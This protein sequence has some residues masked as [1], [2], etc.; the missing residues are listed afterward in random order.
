MNLEVEG[1]QPPVAAAN[2]NGQRVLVS[3]KQLLNREEQLKEFTATLSGIP[4]PGPGRW[5]AVLLAGGMA[6]LGV[7]A[8][9]GAFDDASLGN[10]VIAD[11][12]RAR[13]LLLGELVAL[14]AARRADRIGPRSYEQS[15]V[16]LIDA[17]ARL[18]LQTSRQA[19]RGARDATSAR[20]KRTKTASERA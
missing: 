5:F 7:L 4:T 19:T 2:Q 11:K 17:V 10:D 3:V 6:I 8:A 14:E 20:R 16:A 9:R 12:K 1:F 15:R 18:G 13:E